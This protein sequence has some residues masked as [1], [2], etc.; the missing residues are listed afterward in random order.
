LNPADP[1]TADEKTVRCKAGGFLCAAG[2]GAGLRDGAFF[3]KEQWLSQDRTFLGN[4][5][6]I[7]KKSHRFTL[8]FLRRHDIIYVN[9]K[10][11]MKE[12]FHFSSKTKRCW[13]ESRL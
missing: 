1:K 11:E 8:R 5:L 3:I 7:F 4:S 12:S 9:R 2:T 6:K 10:R 13:E